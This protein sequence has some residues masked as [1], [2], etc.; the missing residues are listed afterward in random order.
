MR[1]FFTL[2]VFAL[3]ALLGACGDT[4]TTPV[5]MTGEIY[6]QV[7]L[8]NEYGILQSD[9]SGLTAQ[10]LEDGK[11]V[12]TVYTSAD[13]K[14]SFKDVAAGIYDF[15]WFKSGYVWDDNNSYPDTLMNT[16]LQFIG[17]G[18]YFIDEYKRAYPH[19][20]FIST[21]QPDSQYYAVKPDI[22]YEVIKQVTEVKDLC[23][24]DSIVKIYFPDSVL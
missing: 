6:G 7:K 8:V 23:I 22:R 5:T 11:I 9:Q 15:R 19:V 1:H 4:S 24:K 18:R 21:A 14:Y 3:A 2:S 12:Q 20:T 16:N 10:I 13:G 17:K